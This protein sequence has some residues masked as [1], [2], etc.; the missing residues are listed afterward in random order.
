LVVIGNGF[1]IAHGL[2]TDYK[3]FLEQLTAEHTAFY[4]MVCQYISEDALWATFEEALS[5][6]DDEQLQDDNSCYL[7]GYGDDNWRDSAHHDFQYMIGK[8]LDFASDI[9]L[10][11]REWIQGINTCV[12][13]IMP[14]H[15]VAPDNL[16]LSF[17]YT[18]TLERVYGIPADHILYIHGKA[19]RGDN[20]ILG[21]HNETLVQDEPE[22]VFE[23]EEER[24]IYYDN[25]SE[26]VRVLEAREIIKSYFKETFKDTTAIIE[27]NHQFFSSLFRI[28]EIYIFGHSL[29]AI[30]FDYFL[31][32][33]RC[34][35]P[36]CRWYISYH[37]EYDFYNAQDFVQSLGLHL[38]ELINV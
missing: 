38:Y 19:L 37:S 32:I 6:L 16:F 22:P 20:L 17:N 24:E 8:A 31:E 25:Y 2:H 15:I 35:S 14:S 30:D 21:H 29:S 12:Q 3:Y 36:T 18:D 34:T 33:K 10:Y 1:D 5:Y 9:P 4:E 11:F 28:Q 26:D 23:T 13:P 27:A 7:L